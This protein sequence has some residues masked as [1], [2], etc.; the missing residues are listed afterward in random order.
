MSTILK[1]RFKAPKPALNILRRDKYVATD[2]ILSNTPA[3]HSGVTTAQLFI[4]CDTLVS[5]VYPMKSGK[6]FVNTDED[7]IRE[8]GAMNHLISD[9]S[10]VEVST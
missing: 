7:N 6:N 9:S 10:K 2:Q 8:R 5:D 1:K 3:V 4:G